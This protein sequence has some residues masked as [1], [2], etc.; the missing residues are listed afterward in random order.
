MSQ[1]L[2]A[3]LHGLQPPLP[4]V[5]PE[6]DTTGPTASGPDAEWRLDEHTREVGRRGIAAARARLRAPAGT[7]RRGGSGRGSPTGTP[8]RA[9]GRAA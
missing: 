7:P 5:D 1:N 8:G 4:L 2:D 3:R 6:D 9:P